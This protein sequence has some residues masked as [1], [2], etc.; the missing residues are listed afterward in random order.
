[1]R[2]AFG[3]RQGELFA[4]E[5]WPEGF[6]YREE[7]ISPKEEKAL[8]ERFALLPLTSFAFRGFSARRLS[9]SRFVHEAY[10]HGKPIAVAP[11]AEQLLETA[12]VPAAAEGIMIAQGETLVSELVKNM[13]QHRFA[14]R[15]SVLKPT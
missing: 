10:C 13:R 3:V 15:V 6:A 12:G 8:A 9:R 11:D 1:M 14:R 7:V 4:A 2:S 5:P